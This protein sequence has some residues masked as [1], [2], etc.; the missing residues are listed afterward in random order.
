MVPKSQVQ[1]FVT[2]INGKVIPD[3]PLPSW[4]QYDRENNKL[5]SASVPE[6]SADDVYTIEVYQRSQ[7]WYLPHAGK[8]VQEFRFQAKKD[9]KEVDV[10]IDFDLPSPSNNP[11]LA[12]TE[13]DLPGAVI[14]NS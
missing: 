2:K 8:I 4:I 1:S 5:V 10:A 3:G 9:K 7:R 6:I 11:Y 14:E 13:P 12:P